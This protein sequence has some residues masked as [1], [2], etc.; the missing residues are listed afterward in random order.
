MSASGSGGSVATASADSAAAA[1][2]TGLAAILTPEQ[3]A[4]FNTAGRIG[5]YEPAERQ[6]IMERY[7]SKR[8]RRAWCKKVRY[9]CR[10]K[11]ADRR[12]RVKGRFIKAEV[13]AS[14]ACKVCAAMAMSY[15]ASGCLLA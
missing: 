7:A 11:L 2:P 12:I 8:T 15:P 10:K 1:A 14:I 4:V 13:A 3:V 5:I 9:G 6:F